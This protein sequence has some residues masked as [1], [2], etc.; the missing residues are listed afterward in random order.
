[1]D[2][3]AEPIGTK[4]MNNLPAVI[5]ESTPKITG[6]ARSLANLAPPWQPGQSGNPLGRPKGI[7]NEINRE[8]LLAVQA[9]FHVHGSATLRKMRTK[10]PARYIEM[11]A[12][13]LPREHSVDEDQ[14]DSFI[15]VLKA[16]GRA[17]RSRES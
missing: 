3:A 5:G 14:A 16:L 17:S 15:E 1:M 7:K 13:L 4:C 9:D 8:F 12:R 2:R 10:N 6:R 11:I